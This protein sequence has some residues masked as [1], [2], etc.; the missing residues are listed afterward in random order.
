MQRT[1]ALQTI[2]EILLQVAR[3][4]PPAQLLLQF[5]LE[6]HVAVL[7]RCALDDRNLSHMASA[8]RLVSAL[9]VA[10]Y[11]ALPLEGEEGGAE[12]ALWRSRHA[13]AD[14]RVETCSAGW[15]GGWLRM[16]EG[17]V[18]ED[19]ADVLGLRGND[20]VVFESPAQ[21]EPSFFPC[22]ACRVSRGLTCVCMGNYRHD[23]Q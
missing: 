1:L 22:A 11:V 10:S 14:T 16:L 2:T 12:E 3:E 21:V 6:N 13:G 9:V 18:E 19:W 4:G 23:K 8:A 20:L 15:R 17:E 5:L 7:A